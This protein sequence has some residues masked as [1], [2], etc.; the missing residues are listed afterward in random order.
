LKHFLGGAGSL[1][2]T[3]LRDTF[4]YNR[5]IYRELDKFSVRS[6][7]PHGPK[8]APVLAFLPFRQNN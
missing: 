4:P 8:A 7:P 6:A 5:E 1:L 3:R 2:R